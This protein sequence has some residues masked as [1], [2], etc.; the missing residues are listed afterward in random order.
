MKPVH[1]GARRNED[2]LAL[3]E[4]PP[5]PRYEIGPVERPGR[6]VAGPCHLA[7]PVVRGLDVAAVKYLRDQRAASASREPR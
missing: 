7:E 5:A 4:P 6:M 2:H 1:R 3:A